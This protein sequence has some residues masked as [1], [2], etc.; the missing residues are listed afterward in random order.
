[1]FSWTWS[2]WDKDFQVF[3]VGIPGCLEWAHAYRL[4]PTD[5]LPGVKPSDLYS[6]WLYYCSS[7]GHLTEFD[8]FYVCLFFF[9]KASASSRGVTHCD[10]FFKTKRLGLV[11]LFDSLFKAA[12][13]GLSC[14][15]FLDSYLDFPVFFTGCQSFSSSSHLTL[16]LQQSVDQTWDKHS[17]VFWFEGFSFYL[18]LLSPW[19]SCIRAKYASEKMHITTFFLFELVVRDFALK[20]WC[21]WHFGF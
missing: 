3:T 1:M 19:P 13:I 6:L 18:K 16:L 9:I 21:L 7:L 12:V 11:H 17:L 15:V 4:E 5:L 8:S 20:L 2:Q 10:A 14:I